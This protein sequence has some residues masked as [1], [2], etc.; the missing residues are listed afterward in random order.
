MAI[1]AETGAASM[2]SHRT[3]ALAGALSAVTMLVTAP[4]GAQPS[5]EQIPHDGA[6]APG[7][8]RP[9][10][11]YD[12]RPEPGTDAVDGLLWVPR[13]LFSPV[14]LVT[15][16]LVRQPLGLLFYELERAGIL[17]A[18][19]ELFTFL[20]GRVLLL[21]TAFFDFGFRPS[22]GLYFTWDGALVD[23]N[24]LSMQVATWGLDWLSFTATSRFAP[25]PALWLVPRVQALRR[26]DQIFGGIGWD[27]TRQGP[28]RFAF[29]GLD[30]S[31][32]LSQRPRGRSAIDY[33]L[34]YRSASFVSQA[35][36]GDPGVAERGPLP[37]GFA[38]GYA[39]VRLGAS[40]T[41]D[42]RGLEE[43][44]TGGLVLGGLLEHGAAF[45]GVELS[46][47]LRWGGSLLLATDALGQG[48]VLALSGQ[49][50]LVSPLQGPDEGVPFHELMDLGGDLG[51]MRAFRPGVIRGYSIVSAALSYVWPIWALL[52][53]SLRVG[54]GNAF[55][56][57]FEDF[58]WERLRLAFD[59]GVRPRTG[60]EHLFELIVGIGTETFDAGAS[61]V[62]V[63]LAVGARAGL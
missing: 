58:A 29:D 56:R 14:Y 21:P 4:T 2:L 45:G 38:D 12:G 48:R 52:D 27:A 17:I 16:R 46:R 49:A 42:T 63:R 39:S 36:D 26:P 54:V 22:V 34:G 15:E 62:E 51:P 41:L 60:G 55:G 47:W 5:E 8:R 25:T 7:Q 59:V 37:V 50:Q 11:H 13:V 44:S 9:V 6:L 24:R 28:A 40:A 30:V 19:P 1:G 32:L 18:I 35:F 43:L 20:D 61:I 33:W 3:T 57:H 31:V 23:D 53:A 10:P